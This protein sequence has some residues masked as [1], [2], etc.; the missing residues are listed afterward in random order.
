MGSRV[1]LVAIGDGRLE[2]QHFVLQLWSIQRT[3]DLVRFFEESSL[4]QGLGVVLFV[5]RD[6][7]DQIDEVLVAVGS[8][9]E[10]LR[11]VEAMAQK[12]QSGS[13]R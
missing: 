1:I 6:I 9:D 12:R 7:R 8:L 10:V 13:G 3:G 4:K 5:L 2:L 11:V